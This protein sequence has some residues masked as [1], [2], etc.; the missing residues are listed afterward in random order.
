[1]EKVLLI[2]GS[3]AS[4]SFMAA[5][6]RRV[7]KEKDRQLEFKARS[8]SELEDYLDDVQLLLV[9]PHLVYMLAELESLC[10]TKNVKVALIPQEIYGSLDGEALYDFAIEQLDHTSGGHDHV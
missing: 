9:G 4:S 8:D 10:L 6:V 1:M 2:C 5:N 7:A 3:G